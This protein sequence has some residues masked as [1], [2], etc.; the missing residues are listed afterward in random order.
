MTHPPCP[1]QIGP[2]LYFRRAD[3]HGL[4]V[5]ALVI[6]PHAMG[7]PGGVTVEDRLFTPEHLDQL[8]ALDVWRYMLILPKSAQGY[9]FEG[10]FYPVVTHHQGDIRI[11]FVSCNGEEI[12]DLTRNENERNAMWLRLG[13]EH[14]A[15]PLAILLQGGD[16]VYADEATDGHPLSDSWPDDLPEEV[17]DEDLQGLEAHL[18]ARFIDRYMRVLAAS[19]PARLMA[20]VPSLAV[21]DDHDICDG[22]GSLK[23]PVTAGPVGQCLFKVARRF[24]LLFQHGAVER[25]IPALFKDPTGASLTWAHQLPGVTLIAPDLRSE[26]GRRQVMGPNGWAAMEGIDVPEGNHV[27]LVSSVPL[28][29]PRLS[30]VEGVMMAIPRM[31]KYEDDLRDQWQSRAHRDEWRRMLRHVLRWHDTSPVTVV[32][33]E[34]HLATRAVLAAQP[35]PV[36]QLVASGISH[37]APPAGYARGLG[38]LA[39][40]GEAP[41]KGHPIRIAPLPGQK[42]RYTAERN[43]L[44]LNRRQD[45]W[46]ANWHLEYSGQTPD[47]ILT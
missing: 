32:S 26:R 33:G 20:R 38:V 27:I 42:N 1:D 11:G 4:H 30:L 29:G 41:L 5:H 15:Q 10:V 35:A 46:T 18:S 47:L 45:H 2:V 19:A 23:R 17:S 25:D 40:L 3:D 14:D 24:Y 8:G 43:F 31:Q 6:R 34:I 44:I 39:G 12:G 22:W 28:L 7:E 36:H 37:R 9:Q 16:Q 21:W 13:L